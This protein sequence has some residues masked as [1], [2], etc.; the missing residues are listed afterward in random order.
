[1]V[2]TSTIVGRVQS[3]TTHPVATLG[4]ALQMSASPTTIRIDI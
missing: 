3:P 1:M 2:T 4:H